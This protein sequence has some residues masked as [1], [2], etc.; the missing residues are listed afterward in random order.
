MGLPK[1]WPSKVFFLFSF[2]Y[3]S[4]LLDLIFLKMFF[5]AKA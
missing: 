3:L 4:D 1:N 2:V 5:E